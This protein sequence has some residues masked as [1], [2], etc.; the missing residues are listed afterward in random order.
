MLKREKV[1]QDLVAIAIKVK[2]FEL[3]RA[4]LVNHRQCRV[5]ECPLTTRN[6]SWLEDNR[7]LHG[8]LMIRFSSFFAERSSSDMDRSWRSALH[9]V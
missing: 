6:L 7:V 2:V 4:S 1:T 5:E 8:R 9:D 3:G